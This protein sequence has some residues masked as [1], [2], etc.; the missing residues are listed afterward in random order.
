M[1]VIKNEAL[2]N[3]ELDPRLLIARLRREV[4]QLRDE[5]SAATGGVA[6]GG[7]EDTGALSPEQVTYV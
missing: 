2:L 7:S 4:E 1:A 6:E 5:L 3:E